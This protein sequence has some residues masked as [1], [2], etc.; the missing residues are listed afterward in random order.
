MFKINILYSKNLLATTNA[1]LTIDLN[2]AAVKDLISIS[3][4]L[5]VEVETGCYDT[6]LGIVSLIDISNKL[7][8]IA[9]TESG[10]YTSKN[11]RGMKVFTINNEPHIVN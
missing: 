4:F 1:I 5:P 6:H 11:C 10:F 2:N 7:K 8:T 9:N 3:K